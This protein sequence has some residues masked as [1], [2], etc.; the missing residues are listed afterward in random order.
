MNEAPRVTLWT[1]GRVVRMTSICLTTLAIVI[2]AACHPGKRL[3]KANVDQVMQGMAKKQ[4]ESILG[5]PTSIETNVMK[6]TTFVYNQGKDTVTIVF[7]EDKVESK[8]TTL[9]D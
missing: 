6:Q 7:K 4:V 1:A 5:V 3:R 9:T 8:A 2:I